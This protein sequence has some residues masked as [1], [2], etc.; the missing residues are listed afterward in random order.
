MGISGASPSQPSNEPWPKSVANTAL[1]YKTS[2]SSSAEIF[3][4][5]TGVSTHSNNCAAV[6]C[7]YTYTVTFK[8]GFETTKMIK[9]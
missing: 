1:S 3:V 9:S 2:G 4:D 7:S 6:G 5:V 8:H